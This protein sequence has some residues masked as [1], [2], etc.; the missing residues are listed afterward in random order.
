MIYKKAD[1]FLTIDNNG[2]IYKIVE[3]KIYK[4]VRSLGDNYKSELIELSSEYRTENGERVNKIDE[5]TFEILF[6]ISEVGENRVI[7]KRYQRK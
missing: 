4:E 6:S 1:Y 5:N 2:K 7:V 3:N